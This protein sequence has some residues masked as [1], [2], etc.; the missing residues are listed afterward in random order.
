MRGKPKF[1]EGATVSFTFDGKTLTGTVFVVDKYGTLE[2]PPM[3]L[4]ILW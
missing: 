2:I 3:Y 4:M 1:K